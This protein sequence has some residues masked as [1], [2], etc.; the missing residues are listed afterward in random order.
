M[1][2]GQLEAHTAAA[3]RAHATAPPDVAGELR[4]TARAE[5]DALQQGA[6]AEVRNDAA[7]AAS[8]SALTGELAARRQQLDAGNADYE[9]WAEA[10]RDVQG[11][12]RQGRRRTEPARPHPAKAGT[13]SPARNRAAAGP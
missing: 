2:R 9:A 6:D 1:D 12:R 7:E 11:H 13:A 5:A 4:L 10:T 8:A 3:E